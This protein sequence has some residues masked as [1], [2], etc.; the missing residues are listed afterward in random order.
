MGRLTLEIVAKTLFGTLPT[1]EFED[2]GAALATI[3]D[4]FTVRGGIMFSIRRESS[5]PATCASGAR[6]ADS[7]P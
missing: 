3:A 6:S 5:P 7:T 2:V 1:R 4:R